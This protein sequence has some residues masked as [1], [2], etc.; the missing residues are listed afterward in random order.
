MS[1]SNTHLL[2]HNGTPIFFKY[3]NED[4]DGFIKFESAR[5]LVKSL[6]SEKTFSSSNVSVTLIRAL[7]W[8]KDA[9]LLNEF[10]ESLQEVL[11]NSF[12][13]LKHRKYRK[14]YTSDFE[15]QIQTIIHTALSYITLSEPL[16]G[17]IIKVP[18]KL[19]NN[20]HFVD[21]KTQKIQMTSDYFGSPYSAYGL[22]PISNLE[23]QAQLLFMGTSIFPT[24]A[25]SHHTV[26][27]D[28]TPGYSV[29]E[30]LYLCGR[31]KITNWVLENSTADK[32]VI[33]VGHSLGGSLAAIAH[34]YQPDR[35]QARVLNSPCWLSNLEKTYKNNISKIEAANECLVHNPIIIT[36]NEGDPVF[37]IGT[38]IPHNSKL[39]IISSKLGNKEGLLIK[40]KDCFA[41]HSNKTGINFT[42]LDP[43]KES[44]K[45]SRKLN[46][47]FWQLLSVPIFGINCVIMLIKLIINTIIKVASTVKDKIYGNF[48]LT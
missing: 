12:Y 47:A 37:E 20:W 13:N 28:F 31:Q 8:R 33:A 1:K 26:M 25:G 38:Y 2:T 42:K 35:V 39:Y 19:D 14:H 17:T 23:A 36:V 24:I 18:V 5:N 45:F 30:S 3:G 11:Q 4:K 34:V 27:T 41:T 16:N 32:P 44:N 9:S 15:L 22:K 21:Y 46:T 48:K 29:G 6:F 7:F 40:H 43:I 10:R